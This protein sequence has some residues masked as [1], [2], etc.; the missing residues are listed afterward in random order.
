[1][2]WTLATQYRQGVETALQPGKQVKYGAFPATA[3]HGPTPT[4][5]LGLFHFKERPTVGLE[6]WKWS[7]VQ[8]AAA[9]AAEPLGATT[10]PGDRTELFT[11]RLPDGC[12]TPNR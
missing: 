8:N 2:R 4:R 9:I 5:K 10:L 12:G 7:L 11:E 1:M 6:G 3:A